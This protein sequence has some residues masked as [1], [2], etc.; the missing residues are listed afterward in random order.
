MRLWAWHPEP[1]DLFDVMRL[2]LLADFM[3]GRD[4]YECAFRSCAKLFV[5]PEGS[6]K[7][8]VSPGGQPP[9]FCS[10]RHAAAAGQQRKRD[11]ERAPAPA[12][13]R[14]GE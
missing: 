6:R 1:L 12:V 11:R 7:S 5:W 9:K 14:R 10:R 8:R 2:Q 3:A 13:D 4:V